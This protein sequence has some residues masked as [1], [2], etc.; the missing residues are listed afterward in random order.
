RERNSLTPDHHGNKVFEFLGVSILDYQ[1]LYRKF[2][3]KGQESYS[4]NHISHVELKNKKVSFDEYGSLHELW[5][6]DYQKFLEYNIKDVELVEM[7][8]HKLRFIDMAISM[9]YDAKVNFY[10]VFAQTRMW[11]SLIY[12]YLM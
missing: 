6:K 8:D 2:S 5:K 12:N 11:D 10:D 1:A 4:L 7:L 9:A 3:L